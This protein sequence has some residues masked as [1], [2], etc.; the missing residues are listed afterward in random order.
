M[1]TM[2]KTLLATAVALASTQAMAAG[3]Q[4]NSQS[5]T[6]VG[7]AA[8]G[9]AIIADN[10]SVLA[11]NPAA[12][13][14]F[15]EAAFS[16]GITYADVMVDV[17]DVNYGGTDLGSIDD[18][19]EGKIIPNIFYIQ[20]LSDRWAIG[21]GAF[22]NFGTGTDTSALFSRVPAGETGPLDLI[23]NTEVTTVNLNASVSYR[24][25]EQF[26]VGAGLD[27][28]YGEGN[29]TRAQGV[30]SADADGYAV[31]G[32]LGA[33]YEINENHRLGLSYR[34]SP[35][36]AA[37]GAVGANLVAN[38]PTGNP[39]L[40]EFAAAIAADFDE[41]EVPLP[42]IFQ[43]AGFHQ[44]TNQ[45]A[46]HYT[47]QWTQ[48]SAFDQITATNGTGTAQ[49]VDNPVV[50]AAVGS[51]IP[52]GFPI[53]VDLGDVAL[54]DYQWKDSWFLSFGGTYTINDKWTVRAG[55]AYDQGVVDEIASLSIPDSDRQWFSAGLGYNLTPKSTID[56]G[57]T[58]V[59]GEEV[60]LTEESALVGPV[61]AVTE[62]GAMY[63]SVQ[64]SH[65]F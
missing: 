17:M 30:I 60:H 48:W 44:L 57:V 37:S 38:L 27:V 64:Y 28:I 63:Y 21:F 45:F 42:D 65:R 50:C 23:G 11:R 52:G 46:V 5:A 14:L 9:D 58:Y 22:S 6:T 54:K 31:G 20:P 8:S 35:T 59:K 32:I 29:L 41:L 3:F 53:S 16:G 34:F 15:D 47:A 36:V 25:N 33:T 13:A 40:P 10:A 12:M 24:I 7:R 4:L 18:A 55:Y 62:S 49:C 19:A 26:S 61:N 43:F 2:N 56:L 51:Q 39:M 1:K